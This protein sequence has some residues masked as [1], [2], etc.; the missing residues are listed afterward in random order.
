MALRQQDSFSEGCY[1]KLTRNAVFVGTLVLVLPIPL[2]LHILPGNAHGIFQEPWWP[3]V[4]AV[5]SVLYAATLLRISLPL[6][7][8]RARDGEEAILRRLTRSGE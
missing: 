8:E 6:A 1:E 2:L 5:L 4:G 7:A 3:P